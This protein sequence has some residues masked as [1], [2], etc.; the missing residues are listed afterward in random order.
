MRWLRLLL[1]QQRRAAIIVDLDP[2]QQ[3]ALRALYRFGPLPYERL[4]ADVTA[5][6]R[7]APADIVG[8]LLRLE[9]ASLIVRPDPG[10][11]IPGP[12]R[13]YRLTPAG[14]RVAKWLPAEPRSVL[15]VTL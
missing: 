12:D 15:G 10:D 14:R 9:A 1:R 3:L 5:A 13:S 7:A 6:R 4:A 8:G 11:R 2:N